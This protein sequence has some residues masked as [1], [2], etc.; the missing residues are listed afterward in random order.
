[1]HQFGDCT[2]EADVDAAVAGCDV[3]FHVAGDTSFWRRRYARQ[4]HVNVDGPD[5]VARACVRHR[6]KRL[7]HTS[8]IDTL[9]S[10]PKGGLVDETWSD[11]SY[12]WYNYAATKRDGERVA[13]SYN[14]AGVEG[15][16]GLEVVV[17]QPGSMLGPFDF[18]LQ[19]GRL[20]FELRDGS[21]PGC[22]CGGSSWAHVRSV[23]DAHVAAATKGRP[24]ECYALGGEN[25]SYKVLFEKIAARMGGK[26]APR[27]VFP[28]WLL[29]L[30]GW[31]C[32]ITSWWTNKPPEMNPEQARY[33]SHFPRCDSSKARRELGFESPP[34][35]TQI[36]DA[37]D[38]YHANG[39]MDDQK[40]KDKSS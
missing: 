28:M 31:L 8:T 19:F 40:D 21:V 15:D 18:T 6:V 37:Y 14:G 27:L 35:D 16:A 1:L 29:W 20:F 33:M 39:F 5:V 25:H 4:R 23:A 38:W 24:G 7:V 2:N 34:L 36:A 26:A 17:L 13:L 32:E 3:V 12:P 30:W 22:P 10:D 11:F 9:G